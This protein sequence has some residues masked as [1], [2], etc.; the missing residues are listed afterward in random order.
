MGSF[1]SFRTWQTCCDKW[2]DQ[3]CFLPKKLIGDC[4]VSFCDLWMKSSWILQHKNKKTASP[5]LNLI[6]RKS[7]VKVLTWIWLRCWKVCSFSQ[8]LQFCWS[9]AIEH[10]WVSQNFSSALQ[11]THYQLLKTFVCSSFRAIHF[12]HRRMQSLM[13]L[14]PS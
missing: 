5:C 6:R 9:T 1:C 11:I 8:T 4:H 13:L 3:F 14:F 2:N 10:Q 7:W 12:S